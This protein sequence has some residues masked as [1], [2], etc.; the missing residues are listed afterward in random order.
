MLAEACVASAGLVRG[1]VQFD[2][3]VVAVQ[4]DPVAERVEE[5]GE[6]LRVD[7]RGVAVE[8]LARLAGHPHQQR[9][10]HPNRGDDPLRAAKAG[11][12]DQFSPYRLA[13]VVIVGMS[14]ESVTQCGQGQLSGR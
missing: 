1:V 4:V 8:A 9:H 6:D 14:G 10:G 13:G 11:A 2:V 12:Q 3:R 5:A 7:V